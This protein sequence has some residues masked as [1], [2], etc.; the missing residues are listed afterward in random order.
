MVTYRFSVVSLDSVLVG[1]FLPHSPTVFALRHN[2]NFLAG[3]GREHLRKTH[4]AEA[5]YQFYKL[6]REQ[7]MN[8]S[9]TLTRSAFFPFIVHLMMIGGKLILSFIH[10][11]A[12]ELPK[13]RVLLLKVTF[14]AADI[15]WRGLRKESAPDGQ[16][17]QC[18]FHAWDTVAH[19]VSIDGSAADEAVRA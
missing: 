9:L 11:T 1:W 8:Q 3:R 5:N 15:R 13:D 7:C 4:S 16:E 19:L 12:P 17:V 2:R 14:K 18:L 10:T 6:E